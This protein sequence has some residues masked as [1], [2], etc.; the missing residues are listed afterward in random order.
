MKAFAPLQ[1]EFMLKGG[2]IMDYK[3]IEKDAFT[4]IGAS[5]M[6]KV[7]HIAK[8][9]SRPSGQSISKAEGQSR[10]RHA[11]SASTSAWA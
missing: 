4:V 1:I 8:P 2:F 9:R 11:L 3:V 6:F 5:K 7:R 10:L